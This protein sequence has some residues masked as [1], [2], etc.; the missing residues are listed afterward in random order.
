[1]PDT[2]V[3]YRNR[4]IEQVMRVFTPRVYLQDS[5][6][7]VDEVKPGEK[8]ALHFD[9]GCVNPPENLRF[10]QITLRVQGEPDEIDFYTN[11]QCN[12]VRPRDYQGKPRVYLIKIGEE[13]WVYKVNTLP[14]AYFFAHKR[15][16]KLTF[17]IGVYAHLIP[18]GK[19]WFTVSPEPW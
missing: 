16:K 11:D 18:L 4:I 9:I 19:R 12:Q 13:F 1:M 15:T 14:Y 7:E 3:E 10:T 5:T 6:Q 8:Y 2:I 17:T